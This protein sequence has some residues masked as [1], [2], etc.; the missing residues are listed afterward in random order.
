MPTTKKRLAENTSSKHENNKKN[1]SKKF[2]NTI[3]QFPKCIHQ[4]SSK[5]HQNPK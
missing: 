1:F 3:Y 4:K 2:A 5:L